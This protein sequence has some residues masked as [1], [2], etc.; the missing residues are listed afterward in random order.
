MQLFGG[1]TQQNL[2]LFGN[3][4]PTEGAAPGFGSRMFDSNGDG[5]MDLFLLDFDNDGTV[6]K[7]VRGVD[8]NGDGVN[9]TFISYNEDGSV[10]S[11]G[12]VNPATG[13]METIYEEPGIIEEILSALGLLDL[14]SPEQALFTSFNDPYIMETFGTFGVE[15]PLEPMDSLVVEPGDIL[16]TDADPSVEAEGVT[17]VDPPETAAES[18]SSDSGAQEELS[19]KEQQAEPE[20][21]EGGEPSKP[22]TA[23]R[24]TEIKDTG[25]SDSSTAWAGVDRDGDNLA[26]DEVLVTKVGDDFVADINRD[27]VS[28]D[29][30]TDMDH[31]GRMDTVDTTGQGSSSDQVDASAVVSPDSA[32]LADQPGEDDGAIEVSAEAAD[33]DVD[34]GSVSAEPYDAPDTS[35]TVDTSPDPGVDTGASTTADTYDS[36]TTTDTGSST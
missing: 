21:A 35:S 34:S 30:A 5:K 31:D 27:G 11:I 15:V 17:V 2:S 8:S 33:T 1:N 26:D 20:A 12:R 18:A 10:E 3:T 14:E 7:V 25:A 24:V 36:G 22:E 32:H 4:Q 29:I 9:D 23:A 16:E 13:E 28:E 19:G 6:D